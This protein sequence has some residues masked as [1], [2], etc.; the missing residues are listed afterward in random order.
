[1]ENNAEVI[2]DPS[3]KNSVVIVE[4]VNQVKGYVLSSDVV[5]VAKG[6]GQGDLANC[7]N[8][9]TTEA[10]QWVTSWL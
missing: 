10:I 6:N 7:F 4:H 5:L 2:C 8:L 9:L 3:S 1:M